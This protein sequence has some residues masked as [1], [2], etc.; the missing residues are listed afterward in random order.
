[1]KILLRSEEANPGG[2]C[3]LGQSVGGSQGSE[4]ELNSFH[5]SGASLLVKSD[6]SIIK[7]K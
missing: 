1:M 5:F 3:N 6:K 7:C 2:P 4:V